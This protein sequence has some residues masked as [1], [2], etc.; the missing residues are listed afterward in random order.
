MKIIVAG[1]GEV[2][3]HLAIQLAEEEMQDIT[4]MDT[5]AKVLENISYGRDLLTF[6]GNPIDAKDLRECN[7]ASADLFVSVMPEETHNLLACTIAAELG[8]PETMARINSAR[9]LNHEYSGIFEKMG[10][11]S[12]IYPEELAADEIN[13]IFRNPW[14]RQYIELFNGN[15]VVVGVKVRTGS[16]IVGKK[17]V[18]LKPEEQKLFHIVAIKRDSDTIIPTGQT[19]IEHG[20]VVFFTVL[21]KDVDKVR[22]FTGKRNVDVNRVVIIGASSTAIRII[23]KAPRS[24]NFVII[25]SNKE[26]INE[27]RNWLPSNVTLYHG[28]GRN[29]DLLNEAGLAYTQVFVA[30]TGNS[31]TNLLACL[32]AKQYGVFKTIAKE[33]HIDYIPVAERFDIGTIINEKVITA[34][35]IFR[36]LL[37]EDSSTVKSLTVAKAD[38]IEVVARRGAYIVGVPV[39]E[40][41]L[42]TGVTL[43]GIVR[44]GIPQLVDGNT[45][46]EPYDLVVAFCYNVSIKKVRKLIESE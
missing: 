39:K 29:S 10:V 26:R 17:L 28:D 45:V 16:S 15:I 7:I 32:M 19:R 30:L 8:V 23:E 37:G 43:G 4:L 42:P 21:G 38:V 11:N 25:E 9:F 13:I 24:I 44:N 12:L 41:N 46:I 22:E 34:G 40:L 1:A 35:H 18:E 36:A 2:G 5:D 20:D 31:E 6:V 27:I 33:E 3:Q 14:A